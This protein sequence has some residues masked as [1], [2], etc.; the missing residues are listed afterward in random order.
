M[1]V[2]I[3]GCGTSAGVPRIG[4]DWGACDPDEPRNRRRRVSILVGDGDTAILVDT[5]PDMRDQLLDAGVATVDAVIWTHEHADHAH[6]IDDLRQLFHNVGAPIPGFA[7]ARCL[8]SLRSRFD[9]VFEG[10]WGYPATVAAEI[11]PDTLTIGGI[12]VRHVE[13]PHGGITSTGLL[14][15]QNGKRIG[16]STDFNEMTDEMARL[17][18]GVDVWIVDALRERPHPTHSHLARTLD[19]IAALGPKRTVLTHMDNSMDYRSLLRQ[20]PPHI[21]P[22]Y[23]G[24]EIEL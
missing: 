1:K 19:Y 17:F 8:A 22:G 18:E 13:Q 11:L 12:A 15:A 3:L 9:Y 23:D 5:G 10:K 20:L 6:G 2:R 24:L 21:E 7:S 4:N 14:F 16:Y